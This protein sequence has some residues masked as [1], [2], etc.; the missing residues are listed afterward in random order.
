VEN[1]DKIG[2]ENL[3]LDGVECTSEGK[4]NSFN[5][6]MNDGV[7]M[8]KKPDYSDRWTTHMINFKDGRKIKMIKVFY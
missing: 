8:E 7:K 3:Y 2:K 5:F 6:R 1:N 4:G